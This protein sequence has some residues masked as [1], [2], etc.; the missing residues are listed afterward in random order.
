MLRPSR[1]V[2]VVL[3]ATIALLLVF[4]ALSMAHDRWHE[5]GQ[6]IVKL[7]PQVGTIVAEKNDGV[8]SVGIASLDLRMERYGVH[9]IDQ[10]FPHK[11]SQLGLIYQFEF[12]PKYS[13]KSVAEDFAA[14]EH[15]LYA[16]PRYRHRICDTP[17]DPNYTNGLQWYL[18]TVQAPDAWSVS[19]GDSSLIIGIVDVGV[20]W[21]HP[22]LIDNRWFNSG[23]DLNGDGVPD[24]NGID[25][26]EN[27]FIDDFYGWDFAGMGVG[28]PDNF[29]DEGAAGHGTHTAGVCAAATDNDLACAGMSWKCTF[30]P[31]KVSADG[32]SDITFGYEGI[33]YAVD[34]GALV[35]NLSWTRGDTASAFEQ[36]IIDSAFA[37][38]A[39]LVAAAGNDEAGSTFAPPDTC[40]LSYPACYS[41][42]TAVA[43]TDMNDRAT[44]FT[45]Y[46]TWV[47]VCA[48][49]NGIFSHLWNDSY[50]MRASTSSA[51]ALVSGVAALLKFHE[52]SVDSDEFQTRM[53]TTSNIIDDLNPTYAGWLGGG[54]LNAY[55]ALLNI[56]QSVE[57]AWTTSGTVP[58]G[59]ALSQNHPNPFNP[60]TTISYSL[61]AAGHATL[62]IYNVGGQLIR[63]L[64]DSIQPEGEYAV[65][66]DGCD[67]DGQRV[68]SGIYFY[69]LSAGNW[70]QAKKMVLMR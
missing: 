30:M 5:S 65:R 13:V 27:G 66:W 51:C 34:N 2:G 49:G 16:E 10:L 12:D 41:H 46:G 7:A 45:Y 3:A 17:N 63:T 68:T 62:R 36:E 61:P 9:R 15:L 59:Y 44:S 69:H 67:R 48:P 18:N 38:G 40:P 20:D 8:I 52:P 25:D 32:S 33:Q 26:D 22:D 43:A 11:S 70:N 60:S 64:V 58:E 53:L 54:R 50:G 47:D 14:D 29:P 19:K 39:I 42:V 55:R 6:I 56:P 24:V 1:I 23:E 4:T 21:N 31:I 28:V 35:I 57:E 37:K